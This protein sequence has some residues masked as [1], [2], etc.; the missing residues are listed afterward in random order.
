MEEVDDEEKLKEVTQNF[1]KKNTEKNKMEKGV[2]KTVPALIDSL[3]IYFEGEVNY[4][5]AG[6]V[7]K[8]MLSFINKKPTEMHA[9]LL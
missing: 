1:E 4:T 9:F 6:Y 2:K 8:V 7:C 3:F 5:L